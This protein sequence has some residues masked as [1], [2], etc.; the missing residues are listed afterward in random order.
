MRDNVLTE[1]PSNF[2]DY[3]QHV[4]AGTEGDLMV[5]LLEELQEEL[6]MKPNAMWDEMEAEF[7]QPN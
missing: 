6:G 7:L 4:L 5:D 2:V 1:V 3:C